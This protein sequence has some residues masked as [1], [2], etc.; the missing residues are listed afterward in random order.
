LEHCILFKNG[1]MTVI[2]KG[3][4]DGVYGVANAMKIVQVGQVL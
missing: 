4:Q 2:T 3:D 1:D